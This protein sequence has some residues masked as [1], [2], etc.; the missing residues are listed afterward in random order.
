MP[1]EYPESGPGAR[2]PYKL[3][4]KLPCKLLYNLPSKLLY[5][6]PPADAGAVSDV[7][8]QGVQRCR[9]LLY[10][11][12][13]GVVEKPDPRFRR[14]FRTVTSWCSTS[15]RSAPG[16]ARSTGRS[17]GLGSVDVVLLVVLGP[18]PSGRRVVLM[19]AVCRRARAAFARP[20]STPE[21]SIPWSSA[22]GVAGGRAEV[23]ELW[24][25]SACTRVLVHACTRY[26]WHAA[27]TARVGAVRS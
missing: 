5:K 4:Y 8:G 27:R 13:S 9:L 12:P 1:G 26:A 18:V 19:A 3:P 2:L 24:P 17:R 14:P 10:D 6:L 25:F 20:V 15:P 11:T 23:H 7:R 16:S 21:V 22:G